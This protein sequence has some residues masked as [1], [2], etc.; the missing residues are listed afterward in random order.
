MRGAFVLAVVGWLTA[1][2]PCA[3]PWQCAPAKAAHSCCGTMKSCCCRGGNSQTSVP[4]PGSPSAKAAPEHP[5]DLAAV[6][7][8]TGVPGSRVGAPDRPTFP[9]VK[10]TAPI[11]LSACAFRC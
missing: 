9:A 1:L 6:Q 7:V 8:G 10:E 11:Y 3:S 5:A 4:E 2:A